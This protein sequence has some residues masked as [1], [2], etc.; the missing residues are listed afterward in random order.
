MKARRLAMVRLGAM[1]ALLAVALSASAAPVRVSVHGLD[2]PGPVSTEPGSTAPA[3]FVTA[4]DAP[5]GTV[6]PVDRRAAAEEE[7]ERELVPTHELPQRPR[8]PH[9]DL[10]RPDET[11]GMVHL[12][13]GAGAAAVP[14]PVAERRLGEFAPPPP[15]PAAP[16]D[17][18]DGPPADAE[19]LT[20]L[21]LVDTDA[22]R[23]QRLAIMMV[24]VPLVLAATAA[25]WWVDRGRRHGRRSRRNA[26]PRARAR[27]R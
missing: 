17:D 5:P 19:R 12:L 1:S 23:Q 15:E 25:W 13:Q 10:P 4:D 22:L 9:L 26:G 7:A 3:R 27:Q 24:V 8:E 14:P 11:D 6:S 20:D 2:D 21:P 16:V 18:I